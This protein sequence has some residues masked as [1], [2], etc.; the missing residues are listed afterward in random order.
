MNGPNSSQK[1]AS[2]RKNECQ[3]PNSNG[4]MKIMYE[5]SESCSAV[6][7]VSSAMSPSTTPSTNAMTE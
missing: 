4:L 2:E 3:R 5:P 1:M 6:R 7:R